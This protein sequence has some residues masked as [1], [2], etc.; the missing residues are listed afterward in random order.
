[1][2]WNRSYFQVVKYRFLELNLYLYKY[3]LM[4]IFS[5]VA[6]PGSSKMTKRWSMTSGSCVFDSVDSAEDKAGV[7]KCIRIFDYHILY[8]TV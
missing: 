2:G 6:A 5:Y 1:M 3:V 4:K 8:N 7:Y